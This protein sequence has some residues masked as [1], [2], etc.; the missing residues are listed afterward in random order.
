MKKALL[1][2]SILALVG[3]AAASGQGANYPDRWFE[4][5]VSR[6]LKR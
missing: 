1:A 2:L 3:I 4:H 5:R 6:L